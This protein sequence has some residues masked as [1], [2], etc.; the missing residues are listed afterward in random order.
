M[1]IANLLSTIESTTVTGSNPRLLNLIFGLIRVF[2]A[3]ITHKGIFVAL[4]L[5]HKD[6]KL[7]KLKINSM[8]LW[9]TVTGA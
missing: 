9:A 5:P 2:K 1:N 6:K 4:K 3:E 8:P 7:T